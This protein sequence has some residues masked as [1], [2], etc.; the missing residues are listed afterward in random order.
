[1][2]RLILPTRVYAGC[3]GVL[4]FMGTAK[5]QAVYWSLVGHDADH[6]EIGALGSLNYEVTLTDSSFCATNVYNG[7]ETAPSEGEHDHIKVRAVII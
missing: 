1:M 5:D 2:S 3:G 7:P 6:Y 4:T